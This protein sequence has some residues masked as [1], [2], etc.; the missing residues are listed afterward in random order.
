MCNE[1]HDTINDELTREWYEVL[2]NYDKKPEMLD[3]A[4]F[5]QRLE[6]EVEKLNPVLYALL[7]ATFLSVLNV[8]M[9][10]TNK[11]GN[12]ANLFLGDNL[13]PYSTLLML[14]RQTILANAKILLPFWYTIPFFS[15]LMGLFNKKPAKKK[16]KA[17]HAVYQSESAGDSSEERK[18]ASHKS[19]SRKDALVSAAK[20]VES[21][22]VP[23]GSTIERELNSYKKQWNRMLTKQAYLN[24]TEDV[25]SL[26]RDYM[27]KILRTISGQSFTIDRIQDLAETLC[28]TPNMQK[29]TDQDSLYVYVQL[30]MIYLVKNL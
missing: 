3:E 14:N 9:A 5:N 4:A 25:N 12:S 28:K 15:W 21:N 16:K 11:V 20:K 24:L 7:N 8:E 26:I 13:L 2:K 17:S 29:I 6:H 10:R 19:E 23:E 18:S 30:Y 22:I 27:R 1:L